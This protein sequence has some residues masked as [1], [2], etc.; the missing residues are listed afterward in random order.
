M[1]LAGSVVTSTLSV[2]GL[3][4]VM[5]DHTPSARLGATDCYTT[6]WSSGTGVFCLAALT[7][8]LVVTVGGVAGTMTFSFTYDG[9][10]HGRG[11][12]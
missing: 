3:N 6:S 9:M 5:R 8:P 1:N 12:D 4:F 7:D 10:Q 11:R 2:V